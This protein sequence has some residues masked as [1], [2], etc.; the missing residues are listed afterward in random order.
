[1]MKDSIIPYLIVRTLAKIDNIYEMRLFG[2]IFAKAQ[3]VMKLYN[4]DLSAINLQ[5]A[6]NL[7]RVTLPARYLMQIGDTNYRHIHKAFK[8]AEKWVDYEKDTWHL[9]LNIIAFPEFKKEG[10]NSMIT[11][12]IHNDLWHALLDFS[13]GYRLINLPTYMKLKSIYSVIMYILITQQ[14]KPMEYHIDTLKKLTGADQNKA[15][16]RTANFITKVIK[17]AQKEL[18]DTSPYT[19][20]FTLKRSGLG[21]KYT[22]II[23]NPIKNPDFKIEETPTSREKDLDKQRIRLDNEVVNYLMHACGLDMKGIEQIENIVAQMGSYDVQIRRIAEIKEAALRN[24]AKNVAGYI[25]N[26]IKNMV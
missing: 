13:Q 17:S 8:L 7:T 22:N 11:F 1:M 3:S 21:G 20:T 6:M 18:N 24:K 16:Q 5:H 19:F 10:R 2:Y 25:V 9:K 26:S 4:K 14:R 23:V 15:Y 12:V